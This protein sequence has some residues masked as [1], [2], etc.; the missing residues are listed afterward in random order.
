MKEKR[1]YII[2]FVLLA[3]YILIILLFNGKNIMR[4]NFDT[5]YIMISPSTQWK[6]EKGTWTTVENIVEYSMKSFQTYVNSKPFGK[7]NVTYNDKFYLFNEKRDSIHYN[8]DL[9]AIKGSIPIGVIKFTKEEI[10]KDHPI[11]K[12]ALDEKKINATNNITASIIKI[13][14]DGKEEQFYIVNNVF[15]TE[16]G[17]NSF[18]LLFTIKEN[19]K[20]Y[21]YEKIEPYEKT[22]EMCIPYIQNIIDIDKDKKYEIIIGCEYYSDNG[23]CHTLFDNE[24]EEYKRIIGSC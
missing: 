9:L 14:I 24:A 10:S 1:K 21:I 15:L 17:E 4:E 8:G 20:I 11:I 23:I 13:N 12:K 18:A 22:L 2:V 5:S 3:S 16:P 6:F 19:K 7:Y